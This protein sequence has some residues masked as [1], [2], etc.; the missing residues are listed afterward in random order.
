MSVIDVYQVFVRDGHAWRWV[1]TVPPLSSRDDFADLVQLVAPALKGQPI[2]VIRDR[3]D[4]PT[5]LFAQP[6]TSAPPAQPPAV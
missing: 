4:P 3:V 1:A 2:R 5:P 6:D